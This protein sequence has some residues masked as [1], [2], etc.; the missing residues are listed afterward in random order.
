MF[1]KGIISPVFL[2]LSSHI[3]EQPTVSFTSFCPGKAIYTMENSLSMAH[4]E[5]FSE[6]IVSANSLVQTFTGSKTLQ[7]NWREFIA[8]TQMNIHGPQK[9]PYFPALISMN[10]CE[11]K[12][13]RGNWRGEG[14]I[15]ILSLRPQFKE[16][17]FVF[18]TELASD[19]RM[20]SF[21][22]A[23]TCRFGIVFGKSEL[24]SSSQNKKY[25][26]QVLIPV[27]GQQDL[28]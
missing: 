6:G 26:V 24:N 25:L 9:Y 12:S 7:G 22:K 13:N 14:V 28:W 27:T 8:K 10:I 5:F 17:S 2:L 18:L 1:S 3:S 21:G 11:K 15:S 19:L 16:G 23:R 20:S 4:S